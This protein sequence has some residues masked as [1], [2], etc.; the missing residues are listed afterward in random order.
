[1]RSHRLIRLLFGDWGL[2]IAKPTQAAGM[3]FSM[4]VNGTTAQ[5]EMQGQR[6]SVDRFAL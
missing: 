5:F 3:R 4:L 6:E 2:M 1:M